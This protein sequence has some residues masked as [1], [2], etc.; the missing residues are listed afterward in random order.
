MIVR[1]N[2]ENVTAESYHWKAMHGVYKYDL[3][4]RKEIDFQLGT[5]SVEVQLAWP[6]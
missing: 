4:P 2:G 3:Y 5:Y 6:S 1:F